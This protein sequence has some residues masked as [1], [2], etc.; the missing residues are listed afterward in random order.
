[1]LARERSLDGTTTLYP[2]EVGL[3][4]RAILLALRDL[5]PHDPTRER[6]YPKQQNVCTAA[7]TPIPKKV[8]LDM[9]CDP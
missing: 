8:S 1:M 5:P 9:R 4:Q 3:S 2:C 7:V 6:C